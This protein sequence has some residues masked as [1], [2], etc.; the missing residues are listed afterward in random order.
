MPA[1]LFSTSEWQH[2]VRRTS[3]AVVTLRRVMG[4]M[5]SGLVGRGLTDRKLEVLLL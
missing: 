4:S 2:R 5:E 1:H 3:G